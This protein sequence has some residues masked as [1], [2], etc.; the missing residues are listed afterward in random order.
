MGHG[1]GVRALFLSKGATKW[2]KGCASKGSSHMRILKNLCAILC[3]TL[4]C[5]Q[6]CDSTSL[7]DKSQPAKQTNPTEHHKT[8]FSAPPSN[9][10]Q[11]Y[12]RKD[13]PHWIDVNV[14]CQDTR[15]EILIR[16][17]VGTIKFKRNK[18][19]NVSWGTWRCP[20]T[21]KIF[22]KASDIDIDHIVPLAHAFKTGGAS[23]SRQKK[24]AFANDPINLLS[25]EDNINQEKGDKAPDEWRPPRQEYWPEYARKWRAVKKKYRLTISSSEEAA[26]RKMEAIR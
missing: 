18:P 21:G 2:N 23:W 22:T 19:C 9:H 25:V 12:N 13:W 1:F 4:L 26:L 5:V 10:F 20:Y 14:D 16:D 3:F 8:Y 6:D 11:D 24:R 15:A 17:N 7:S